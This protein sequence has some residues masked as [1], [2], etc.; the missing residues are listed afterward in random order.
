MNP[1][2]NSE[3]ENCE[4]SIRNI[5]KINIIDDKGKNNSFCN[6]KIN[7]FEK[8]ISKKLNTFENKNDF[9][10]KDKSNENPQIKYIEIKQ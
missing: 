4:S 2:I 1:D 6:S 9:N 3:K 10:K 7:Y 8:N 5:K